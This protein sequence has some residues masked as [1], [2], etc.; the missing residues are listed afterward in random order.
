MRK[1]FLCFIHRK[2]E[3]SL[4]IFVFPVS[5]FLKFIPEFPFQRKQVYDHHGSSKEKQNRQDDPD[6]LP[7]KIKK[8]FH[9]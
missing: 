6:I 5:S 3:R 8:S 4:E 7:D 9:G 1:F 2:I